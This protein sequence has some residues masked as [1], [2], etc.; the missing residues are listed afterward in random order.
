[1][2]LKNIT[3]SAKQLVDL[4][5]GKVVVVDGYKTIDLDRASY[6]ENAFTLIKNKPER[7]EIKTERRKE[8]RIERK[9]EVKSENE[10]DYEIEQ[11][12]ELKTEKEVI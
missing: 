12:E 9:K 4:S 1:M 2:K 11:K 5:T 3:D 8:V 7:K 6:N 10:D